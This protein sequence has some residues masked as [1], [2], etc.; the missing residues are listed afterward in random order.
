MTTRPD[1]HDMIRELTLD[2]KQATIY[3]HETNGTWIHTTQTPPLLDQLANAEK[4]T[5]EE[6]GFAGFQPAAPLWLEP[7][8]TLALIDREASAWIRNLGDDDPPTAKEC[9]LRLHGLWAS[10]TN[11]AKR[12]IEHDVRRWWTQARI[13]SGWD[14]AA[15]KPDNTCPL[16]NERRSLRI[17]LSDQA[18]FC[19]GC[20]E[21]WTPETIGLL[22]D[23][24]RLENR[25]DEPTDTD[26]A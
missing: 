1:I 20:R 19:T 15:W 7:L 3:D 22:V 18:G 14:S 17:K 4:T 16:C 11:Q 21:T 24:I 13:I 9:V 6:A 25:E 12:D 23:H 26:A 8:D 10:A 5:H 2:H